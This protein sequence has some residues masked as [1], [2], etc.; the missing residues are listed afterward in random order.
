M[1]I[2][3]TVG[4]L[5]A[6][7]GKTGRRLG[8]I[9]GMRNMAMI[10]G[11]LVVWF[12]M[13]LFHFSY[14]TLFLVAAI[15]AVFSSI[16]FFRMKLPQDLSVPEKRFVFNQKYSIYYLL[17]ILFGARKQIFLTFSTWAIS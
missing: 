11:P 8:Q 12:G 7:D 4:L 9:S 14:K 16:Q 1:P 2:E 10:L 5:L 3:S 6:S 15:F 13:D 17:N